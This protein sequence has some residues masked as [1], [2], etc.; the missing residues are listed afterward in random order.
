[1]FQKGTNVETD[2]WPIL[3]IR[4]GEIED[5]GITERTLEV[6]EKLYQTKKESF[7]TV[8][9]A[10]NGVRPSPAQ[11]Y[12][13]VEFRRKHEDHIKQYSRGTAIVCKSEILRAVA[14]AMY[15][16]KAPDNVTKMF[17]DLDDAI[18]WARDQLET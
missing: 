2:M 3:I 9:D 14:T 6:V 10:S 8:L 15:W 1:M 12:V 4:A 13:Q 18:E 17:T 7:V 16:I 5:V 11:R